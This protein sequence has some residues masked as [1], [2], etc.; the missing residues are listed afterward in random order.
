MPQRIVP[1]LQLPN[2]DDFTG[3]SI[4]RSSASFL[5]NLGASMERT[6]NADE[7]SICITKAKQL[8]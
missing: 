1:Y 4:R 2:A 7:R 8:R 3:H 6:M 5:A